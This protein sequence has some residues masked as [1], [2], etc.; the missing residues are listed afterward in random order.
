MKLRPYQDEAIA[1]VMRDFESLRKLLI[2]MPTGSGKTIVFAEIARRFVE[3]GKRVLVLAHRRELINQA[4][5]KIVRVTKLA[6]S[7]HVGRK[8]PL[9]TDKIVIGSIQGITRCLE[10]HYGDRNFD[11]IIA[12][13]AHHTPAGTWK[14]VVDHFSNSRILGVTA[15]PDRTDEQSLL[16][17]FD[18]I[19]FEISIEDLIRDGYL[20]EITVQPVPCDLDLTDVKLSKGDLSRYGLADALKP[21]IPLI[22]AALNEHATFRK[23][24]AFW[25]LIDTSLDFAD[26]C[27]K[28]N[29]SDLSAAHIDGTSKDLDHVLRMFRAGKIDVLSNA[30]LLTEGFDEPAIDCVTP[31]RATK[32]RSLYAQMIGR[33][34]R[35][36]PGKTD[37]LLLDFLFSHQKFSLANPYSVV[38]SDACTAR[39]LTSIR[40]G[41]P[42]NLMDAAR[43]VRLEREKR[44]AEELEIA[45]AQ[46]S[47][48]REWKSTTITLS[49]YFHAIGEPIPSS[50]HYHGSWMSRSPSAKQLSLLS[51]HGID[52]DSVGT[53]GFASAGISVLLD[54]MQRKRATPRQIAAIKKSDK[55]T[56]DITMMEAA[57]LCNL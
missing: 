2:V 45:A 10:S 46:N 30:S 35:I 43:N 16:E 52:E 1:N 47:K 49:D 37:L 19:S 32:S 25:P 11:L 23:S 28:S 39:D 53:A 5:S 41:K 3:A 27:A 21:Y 48:D 22:V 17:V 9:G 34:T 36:H 51:R 38:S 18:K 42:V 29:N 24:L 26:F 57:K 20:S 15:T 54:R 50:D 4:W 13:E 40:S 33:G 14:A 12:D 44:L 7:I 31:L 56:G 8:A 55:W 6:P